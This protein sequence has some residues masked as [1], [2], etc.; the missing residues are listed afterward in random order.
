MAERP[1]FVPFVVIALVVVAAGVGLALYLHASARAA[2]PAPVITVAVGD[3]VTVNYIGLFGSGPQNGRVFDTSLY[4]VAKNGASWPKSLEY[5]P[6]SAINQYTPLP[7]HVGPYTPSSGYTI[8]NRSFIGVVPGFWIGLLGLPGNQTHLVTVPP[9]LGYGQGSPGCELNVPLVQ[10][11]PVLEN[12]NRSAFSNRFHGIAPVTGLS[13]LDPVFHWPIY[14]LSVN[15]TSVL[16]ENAASVGD[17][18][19]PQGWPVQVVN[20]SAQANGTGT[21]QLQ[22]ELTPAEAGLLSGVSPAGPPPGCHG[23]PNGAFII[24]SVDPVHGTFTENFNAEVTGVT[25]IFLVTV[26]DIFP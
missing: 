1:S 22:N 16:I 13:F 7:V 18:A 9:A 5:Q 6:K 3:N 19:A 8:G 12:L 20:V 23:A 26:V 25:L 2:H 11:L 10:T 4:G 15:S 14:V 24:S 21:I 17:S